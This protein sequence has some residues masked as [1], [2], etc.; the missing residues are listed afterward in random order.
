MEVQEKEGFMKFR[1]LIPALA[2]IAGT[3]ACEDGD[4]T[5]IVGQNTANVRFVNAVSGAGGNVLL[6]SNGTVVGSSQ[7]FGSFNTTCAA[8]PAGTGRNLAFGTTAT[9]GTTI[10]NSLGTMT[11]NFTAGRNYTVIASGSSASPTLLVLDNTATAAGTGNANVRFVNATGQ[12][13]DFF[14][15]SGATLGTAT[16]ANVGANANS[17]FTAIPTTNST[18]TFRAV[19]N[20]TPL[21]TTNGTF[22]SGQNYTVLLLPNSTGTG[23]QAVTLT[24]C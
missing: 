12:A 9:G 18:L 24:G 14:T 22:V 17:T 4:N 23:F 16:F 11:T 19:G 3:A 5:G 8:V 13:V 2:L 20:T 21:F 6:T 15:T 7:G 1:T 10:S